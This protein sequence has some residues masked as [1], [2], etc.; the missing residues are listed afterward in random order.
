MYTN[1]NKIETILKQEKEA[2]AGVA[3]QDAGWEDR[4]SSEGIELMT[5]RS[6]GAGEVRLMALAQELGEQDCVSEAGC[7]E[8]R[9]A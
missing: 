4:E 9:K 1:Q 7:L 8:R 2:G 5:R 3:R 6:G